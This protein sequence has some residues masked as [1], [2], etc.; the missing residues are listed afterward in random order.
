MAYRGKN[1]EDAEKKMEEILN[2]K[3]TKTVESK[4]TEISIEDMAS[5]CKRKGFV[6]Q[7]G[8]IYGGLAGFW[9][10]G[11][12]GVE[13]KN[14]IKK[15]RWKFHVK[16]RDDIV[17]IDGSII[18]NPKVWIASGHVENF[19]D[20]MLTCS[21]CKEKIRAD[22]FIEDNLKIAADGMKA[23]EIKKL[24]KEKDLKCTKCKSKFKE[25]KQ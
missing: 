10:Y 22:S 21:K 1:R 11:H 25:E 4:K 2:K 6:Y 5:F 18:T 3:E 20:L 16:Q 7:S 9:D 15:E 24:L 13:L 17:G 8:D 12:L 14:N 19:E 23:E